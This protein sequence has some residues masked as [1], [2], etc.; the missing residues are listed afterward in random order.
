MNV[1]YEVARFMMQQRIR[2]GHRL[3]GAVKQIQPVAEYDLSDKIKFRFPIGRDESYG[4]GASEWRKYESSLVG[5]F[6]AAIKDMHEV[7]LFD[8]GADLGIFSARVCSQSPNVTR[9][10]AFEPNTAVTDVLKTNLSQ[11]PNATAVVGGVSNFSGS[12]RLATP[13][14]Y[15]ADHARY[16]VPS[17][18]GFPVVTL[19]SFGVFGG[20]VGI[21]VDV[22]GAELSVLEGASKTIARASKIVLTLEVHAKVC[23]RTGIHPSKFLKFLDSIRSF[24]YTIAE[25]GEQVTAATISPNPAKVLNVVAL[26]SR[27]GRSGFAYDC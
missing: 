3:L 25:T 7:T 13:S 2:G 15:D 6:C 12:A 19:D 5:A 16:I 21:K 4:W 1:L 9:V 18:D 11:L 26:S 23:E 10:I 8:C 20:D 17:E 27:D 22:E 14:Y 24:T